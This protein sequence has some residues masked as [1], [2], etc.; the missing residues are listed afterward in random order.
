MTSFLIPTNNTLHLIYISGTHVIDAA[1]LNGGS[2]VSTDLT[3]T[4]SN[5]TP[6]GS[7]G[8]ALTGF[9]LNSTYPEHAFFEAANGHIHE[10]WSSSSGAFTDYDLT[11]L[12]GG[13]AA[14]SGSSLTSFYRDTTY[15]EHVFFQASNNHLHELWSANNGS[16]HDVDITAASKG[17][18]PVANSTL[19]SFYWNETYPEHVFFLDANGHVH[20][21]WEDNTSAWHDN[22]LTQIT[23]SGAN[24][25]APSGMTSFLTSGSYSEHVI[26][27]NGVTSGSGTIH[28]MKLSSSGVWTDQNL[29]ALTS[30]PLLDTVTAL[31]GFVTSDVNSEHAFYVDSQ[32]NVHELWFSSSNSTWHDQKVYTGS[33]STG[34]YATG[35]SITALSLST[36]AVEAAFWY[37][38][39]ESDHSEIGES[40]SSGGSWTFDAMPLY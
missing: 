1:S 31:S 20:E 21:L 40:A 2:F 8:S 35:G 37:E 27:E 16:W 39:Y 23:G 28:E 34:L 38:T 6:T 10:L 12:S 22:D 32:G 29:T 15:P 13:A 30:G 26:Y 9:Y 17:S 3:A 36:S 11:S 19:T 33:L 5:G 14:I 18:T 24:V 7:S 4:A 25:Y